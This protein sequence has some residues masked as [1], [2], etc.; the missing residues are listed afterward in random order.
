M[1]D[2]YRI[3][4]EAIEI[5]REV[6][7]SEEFRGFL[8]GN[9]YKYLIRHTYK[10]NPIGDLQKAVDYINALEVM[11]VDPECRNPFEVIRNQKDQQSW[12]NEDDPNS[13]TR[14]GREQVSPS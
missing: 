8:L 11:L 10:G 13:Q 5:M 2:H 6:L 9:A 7:T 14:S 1:S 4:M 3:Q 12:Q